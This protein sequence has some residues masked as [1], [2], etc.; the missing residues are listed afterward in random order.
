MPAARPEFPQRQVK[1]QFLRVPRVDWLKVRAGAKTELRAAG[2]HALG[3]WRLPV[4]PM[5]V[6]GY[7]FQR[8]RADADS[9]LLIVEKAWSEPLGSITA[10]SLAAEGFAELA[11]FKRYWRE[12]HNSV[13]YKPLS[14]VQVVQL[15]P[16]VP[17]TDVRLIGDV[18]VDR[19]FGR[20]L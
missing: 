6:V 3:H 7:S 20:W 4:L 2:R 12:R 1:T 17:E 15:R 11:D 18:L 16:F 10:E 13:G 5:A 19:L 8:F 9:C 14:T